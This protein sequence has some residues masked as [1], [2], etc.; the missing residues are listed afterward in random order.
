MRKL[1]SSSLI[2]PR[3]H[4]LVNVLNKKIINYLRKLTTYEHKLLQNL[5]DAD[6][7][8]NVILLN[9]CRLSI[10]NQLNVRLH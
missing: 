10:N 7:N 4:Q 9:N 5:F 2:L 3:Q 8:S 1:N 6:E